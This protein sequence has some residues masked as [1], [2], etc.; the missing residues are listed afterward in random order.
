MILRNKLAKKLRT[1]MKF[2]EGFVR[3]E[4][5]AFD[6]PVAFELWGDPDDAIS[7]EV[8][9]MASGTVIDGADA[10]SLDDMAERMEIYYGF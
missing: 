2:D 10:L 6:P 5:P 7:C 8:I 9:N 4:N 3:M 1:S